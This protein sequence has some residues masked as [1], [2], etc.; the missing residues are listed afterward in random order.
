M[1]PIQ[2][3]LTPQQA[4]AYL[5]VSR[6]T[7]EA[8]RMKGGGPK[9]HRLTARAVRYRRDELDSWLSGR[10]FHHTSEESAKVAA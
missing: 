6:R 1:T 3:Y 4:A 9:Y 10:S 7:L 2:P 5:A 8:W